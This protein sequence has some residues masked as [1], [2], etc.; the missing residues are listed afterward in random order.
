[1]TDEEAAANNVVF[2]AMQLEEKGGARFYGAKRLRCARP[3][4]VHLIGTMLRQVLEPP[5][6]GNPYPKLHGLFRIYRNY[7][8]LRSLEIIAVLQPVP[9]GTEMPGV[10]LSRQVLPL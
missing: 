6:I 7:S 10:V 4:E 3:P 2:R 8:M 5:V 1:V 9:P